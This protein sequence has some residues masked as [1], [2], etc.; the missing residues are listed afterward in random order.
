MEKIYKHKN[1]LFTID[2]SVNPNIKITLNGTKRYGYVGIAPLTDGL[3]TW[4]K[5]SSEATEE[6]II[7]K[8]VRRNRYYKNLKKVINALCK[9][10]IDDNKYDEELMMREERRQIARQK[11]AEFM[12]KL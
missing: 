9:E 4:T 6:G 8:I 5:F 11:I 3:Y 10:L 12:D 1:R 2:D 7:A